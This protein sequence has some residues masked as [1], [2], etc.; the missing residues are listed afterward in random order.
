M[1]T[2]LIMYYIHLSQLEYAYC[3]DQVNCCS[4]SIVLRNQAQAR[5]SGLAGNRL[6]NKQ[7]IK[8]KELYTCRIYIY[9]C[10]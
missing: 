9:V 8:P 1:Y 5:H 10:I 7:T 4:N 6:Q 3:F 2:R